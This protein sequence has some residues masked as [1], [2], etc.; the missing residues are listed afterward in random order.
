MHEWDCEGEEATRSA[1]GLQCEGAVG[2]FDFNFFLNPSLCYCGVWLIKCYQRSKANKLNCLP[3][4]IYLARG[5]VYT[6][7]KDIVF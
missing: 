6:K 3:V 4:K 2:L 1:P 7:R 5:Q